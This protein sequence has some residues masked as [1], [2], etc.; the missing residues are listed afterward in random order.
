VVSCVAAVPDAWHPLGRPEYLRFACEMSL[1]RLGVDTIDLYQLH[2]FDPAVPVAD[3]VGVLADLQREGKI[4][5]IGL[6]EVDVERIEE[7]RRE[8]DVVSV[9]NMYNVADRRWESVLDH[10]EANGIGFVPW[11]PVGAGRVARPG[12][13]LDAVAADLDATPSQV[14]LAWLLA[15]SPVL[16]PIPGTS[17]PA[18]LVENCAAAQL[19]LT[20]AQVAAVEAAVADVATA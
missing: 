18:H 5:H 6:S 9:Q 16:L 19:R 15:R 13:P 10:C 8:V 1:R 12:G 11:F 17:S 3:Q 7:V 2:R 14:A 4:R 20:P